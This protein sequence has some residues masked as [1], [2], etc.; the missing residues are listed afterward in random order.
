[1]CAPLRSLSYSKRCCHIEVKTH[2]SKRGA[3]FFSVS[4]AHLNSF[5]HTTAARWNTDIRFVIH[6]N[7]A[8]NMDQRINAMELPPIRCMCI[9]EL[10]MNPD[11]FKCTRLIKIAT[12]FFLLLSLLSINSNKRCWCVH[13]F[14][15]LIFK[16]I[17]QCC[18]RNKS[19]V[20]RHCRYI[21]WIKH[22][23]RLAVTWV[24]HG[25]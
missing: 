7:C 6:T 4:N 23:K 24:S 20:L 14:F 3:N 9:S 19:F 5:E 17:A 13:Y 22:E 12:F 8:L 25:I 21:Q 11:A 15:F 18:Y 10:K 2:T 16:W 1:M